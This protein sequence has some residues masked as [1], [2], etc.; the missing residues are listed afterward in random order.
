MRV[1]REY[2]ATPGLEDSLAIDRLLVTAKEK[3]TGSGDS[4]HPDSQEAG[5]G[6]AGTA[7]GGEEKGGKSLEPKKKKSFF[8][9]IS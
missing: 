3:G 2:P 4:F 6:V 7:Q 5:K 1:L 9:R 8:S